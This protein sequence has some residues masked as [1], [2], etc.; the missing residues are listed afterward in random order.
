MA[1]EQSAELSEEEYIQE[2]IEAARGPIKTNHP[3]RVLEYDAE[4]QTALVQPILS[5]FQVRWELED[6]GYEPLSPVRVPVAFPG[7]G[8]VSLHF[9]L[10]EGTDGILTICDRDTKG[11]E[12]TGTGESEPPTRSRFDHRHAFFV[13]E[14]RSPAT[15]RE[16]EYWDSSDEGPVFHLKDNQALHVAVAQAEKALAM[17]EKVADELNDLRS[18][19][20]G[21][22]HGIPP[23]IDGTQA[24]VTVVTSNP[25]PPGPGNV[26]ATTSKYRPLGPVSESDLETERVKVDK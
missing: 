21:H 22:T 25:P 12:A 7:A 16:A 17:A 1:G 14:I 11:W 8:E 15:P 19:Y 9:Y 20:N 5:I 6:E 4:T 23:L 3:A 10:D 18:Q 26:A 24:P 2:I 13:P